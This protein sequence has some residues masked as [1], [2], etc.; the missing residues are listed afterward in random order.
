MFFSS[1]VVYLIT[2]RSEEYEV[3]N[4]VVC[5]SNLELPILTPFSDRANR[6]LVGRVDH[7]FSKGY[8][9]AGWNK[10]KSTSTGSL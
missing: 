3:V 2:L 5:L 6:C 4:E 8:E 9:F 7:D 10:M 1:E